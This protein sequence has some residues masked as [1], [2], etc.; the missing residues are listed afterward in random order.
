MENEEA[1]NLAKEGPSK[2]PVDQTAVIPFV[3]G[4]EVSGS[5]LRQEYLNRWKAYNG[6]CHSKLLMSEHLPRRAEEFQAMSRLKIK[7]AVVLLTG[8]T[9]STARIFNLRLTQQQDC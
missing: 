1:D 8:F 5:H 2:L 6:Y 4:K 9:N 7:V 3:V